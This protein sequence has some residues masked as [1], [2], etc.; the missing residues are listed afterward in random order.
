[1]REVRNSVG[2]I[3]VGKRKEISFSS[4]KVMNFQNMGISDR[5]KNSKLIKKISEFKKNE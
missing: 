2:V 4:H 5:K 1:M 3:G